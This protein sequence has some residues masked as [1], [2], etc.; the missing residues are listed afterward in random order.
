MNIESYWK[1]F[2]YGVNIDHYT[3][4]L[5]SDSSWSDLLALDCFNNHITTD[6]RTLENIYL[7]L[8][9]LTTERH[10]LF[11]DTLFFTVPYIFSHRA[12]LF[13]TPISTVFHCQNLLW[14]YL[15]MVNSILP[16]ISN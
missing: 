8:A 6:I 4:L 12:A 1:L 5:I 9:R 10:F 15:L 2:N 11:A 16:K 13:N 7:Y 3:K 14:R